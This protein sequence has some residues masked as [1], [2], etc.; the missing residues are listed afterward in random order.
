MIGAN[1][2]VE[3][4]A[5]IT[6]ASQ[7]LG[8]AFA[9]EYARRKIN[10]VLVSLPNQNLRDFSDEISGKFG[11]QS[12]YFET[13]LAISENV[14][15][16]AEWI[17]KN[18]EVYILINNVGIGG[19][20]K[21]Q[22]SQ[23]E[24]ILSILQVNVVA[25]A[26]LT[27][28]LLPNMMNQKQSYILNVSS[29]AAFSPIGFKTVY[30]ASKTFI[31]CFSRSLYAELKD[32]NVFVSVVNPG[33]MRTNMDTKERIRKQGFFGR[34]TLL[35]PEKVA[36]YCIRQLF[37]RDTVI[38]VNGFSWAILKIL[39][40]WITLPLMTRAVKKEISI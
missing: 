18:F 5:V 27:H 25:T 2:S 36:S 12:S 37:N 39:P 16:L 3:Q 9:L 11:I 21:F 40:V 30:P 1:Q 20:K 17:N 34:I 23:V 10:V 33:A 14:L 35:N 28:Q 15:E 4:F 31:H 32:T 22:D 29:M 19:T 38:M 13:D 6:G 7:G 24:Y 8:R 26:L